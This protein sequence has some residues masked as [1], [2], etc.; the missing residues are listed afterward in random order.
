MYKSCLNIE[1]TNDSL[2]EK[3]HEVRLPLRNDFRFYLF[4]QILMVL[5]FYDVNVESANVYYVLYH[6]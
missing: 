1:I 5:G 3:Y 6:S 4:D 2:T